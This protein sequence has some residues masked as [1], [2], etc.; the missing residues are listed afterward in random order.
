MWCPIAHEPWSPEAGAPGR[1]PVW[2]AYALL[3][4]LSH[5]CLQPGQLQWSILH[6]V[7]ALDRVRSLHCWGA[8]LKTAWA[9]RWAR[10]AV[11]LGV[12]SRPLPQLWTHWMAGLCPCIASWKSQLLELDTL[13]CEHTEVVSLPRAEVTLEWS[14]S[15]P[16]LFAVCGRARATLEGWLPMQAG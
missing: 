9:C 1:Y 8:C 13:R 3:L 4:W 15:L 7:G 12:C 16:G 6:A 11:R 10:S 2:T 5:I 14:C